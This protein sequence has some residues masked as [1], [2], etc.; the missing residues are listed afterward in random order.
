M[1]SLRR[2]NKGQ[3]GSRRAD[4]VVYACFEKCSLRKVQGSVEQ[5][6]SLRKVQEGSR[7]AVSGRFK[8]VQEGQSVMLREV[9]SQ[10]GSRRFKKG[11]LRKVQEVSS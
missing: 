3:E 7:R 8:K 11:S 2:F 9:Q 5:S 4:I 6:A 10:E 1:R